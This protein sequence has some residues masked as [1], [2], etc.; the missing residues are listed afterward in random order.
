VE[1]ISPGRI[2][3][4]HWQRETNEDI[5]GFPRQ[6]FHKLSPTLSSYAPEHLAG[7]PKRVPF[8]WTCPPVRTTHRSTTNFRGSRYTTASP[9]PP[10]QPLGVHLTSDAG[11]HRR[12]GPRL[13]FRPFTHARP[14]QLLLLFDEAPMEARTTKVQEHTQEVMS[15]AVLPVMDR[16]DGRSPR[17]RTRPFRGR[18]CHNPAVSGGRLASASR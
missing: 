1:T 10:A 12:R 11:N 15:K 16:Y 5:N 6:Y 7:V 14:S 9:S 4:S 18:F 17:S 3:H 2:P 8:D 13:R